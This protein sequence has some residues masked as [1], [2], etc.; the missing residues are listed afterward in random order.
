MAL[1]VKDIMIKPVLTIDINKNAKLVGEIMRQT[2]RDALIVTKNRRPVGIIT[3]SDL[4]KKVVAKNIKPSSVKVKRLMSKPLVTIKPEENVVDAVRKMKKNNIKRLPVVSEGKLVALIS[5]SD[6]ARTSPDMVDL[7]EYKLKMKE[8]EPVIKERT[9]SGICDS[10]GEY[11]QDL[12]NV[13][14]QWFCESC[15][16][17]VEE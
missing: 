7:L 11:S 15:R 13:N 14:G 2:R 5:L 4:I 1:L 8:M 9:T 3:D 16:E 10:C 6:V 17:E 12:G